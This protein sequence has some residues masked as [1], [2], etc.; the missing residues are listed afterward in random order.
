M[1][2]SGSMSGLSGYEEGYHHHPGYHHHHQR[3]HD[4]MRG[5]SGMAASW[6]DSYQ[7]DHHRRPGGGGGGG[8]GPRDHDPLQQ[9]I[10]VLP[11]IPGKVAKLRSTNNGSI[12]H[13][14]GTISKNNQALQ[15]SKSISSPTYQQHQQQHPAS[16]SECDEEL[17]LS[18]LQPARSML[19]QRSRTQLNLMPPGLAGGGAGRLTRNGH[20]PQY[21]HDE[22]GGGRGP[23]ERAAGGRQTATRYGEPNGTAGGSATEALNQ[24]KRFGSEPD[25]R[26]SLLPRSGPGPEPPGGSR[27]PKMAQSKIMKGKNKKK[28]PVPP[29]MEKLLEKKT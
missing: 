26:L 22:D 18:S 19:M 11:D 7:R 29:V 1:G 14:G 13:A 5:E 27:N 23:P 3:Y 4:A 8:V 28:A 12:L 10:K 15:R 17:E 24:R 20:A 16:F 25:L 6:M 21:G 9:Q 2:N